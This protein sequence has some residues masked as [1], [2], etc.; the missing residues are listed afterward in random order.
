MEHNHEVLEHDCPLQIGEN[1]RLQPLDFSA[2]MDVLSQIAD[3]KLVISP[4]YKWGRLG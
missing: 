1:L 3:S 2:R 4:T